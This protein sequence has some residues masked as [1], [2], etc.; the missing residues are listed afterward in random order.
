[1]MPFSTYL[2]RLLQLCYVPAQQM[3]LIWQPSARVYEALSDALT[4]CIA[5]Q[6]PISRSHAEG[7]GTAQLLG[8]VVCDALLTAMED[9]T[10][11]N[12]C[13]CHADV[14]QSLLE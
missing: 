11:D 6:E 13:C 14:H 4:L 8:R 3:C 1:M 7:G 9:Y 2:W 10:T 12:R 5:Q